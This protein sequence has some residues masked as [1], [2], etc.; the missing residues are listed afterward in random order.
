MSALARRT[1]HGLRQTGRLAFDAVVP[2]VC[3][4][5]HAPAGE[6]DMLCPTCWAKA[7]FIERPYCERLGIPQ[8]FDMPGETLS[9]QAIE[10]PPSYDRARAAL[11]YGEI[12]NRLIPRF[13]YADRTELAPAL[14]RLMVRAGAD[15]FPD[16][17]LLVPVPLH[18]T[19]LWQRRFNQ[20]AMLA[21]DVAAR[22]GLPA[23]LTAL[24]RVRRTP[25]QVGLPRKARHE[26]MAG[27]FEVSEAGRAEIAGRSVILVDDV[28]TSGA[29]ADACARALRRAGARQVDVLV[30]AR[31]VDQF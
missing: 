15:L 26:N 30:V 10:D 13:K 27:A 23:N 7:E 24:R 20:S 14:A 29:T 31:V 25:K 19:R 17:D 22:T 16:A 11:R 5:C 12:A 9:Q 21:R 18:W 3:V 8:P 2:P 6:P 28:L 1:F 4:A